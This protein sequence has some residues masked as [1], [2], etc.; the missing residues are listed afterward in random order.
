LDNAIN[1]YAI[2]LVNIIQHDKGVAVIG[3]ETEKKDMM[4]YF[5]DTMTEKLWEYGVRPIFERQRL[6]FLQKELNYSLSGEVSDETALSVGKRTGVNTVIYGKLIEAGNNSYRIII[7]AANVETAQLIFPKSYNL[8][9]DST[10]SIFLGTNDD[11][12]NKWLYLGLCAFWS[13]RFHYA[14]NFSSHL[15]NISGG[16]TTELHFLNFMSVAIGIELNSDA[17]GIQIGIVI[18]HWKFLLH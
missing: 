8:K 18:M 9:I 1:D 6:E 10:L 11:W 5:I 15:S 17:L 3:F 4:E 7:R 14:D 12:R 2:E 16:F 13:P